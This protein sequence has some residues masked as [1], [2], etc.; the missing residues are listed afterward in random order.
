MVRFLFLFSSTF[1]FFLFQAAGQERDSIYLYNGQILIGTIQAAGLGTITIDDMDFKMTNVK[2]YKIRRL[3]IGNKFKVETIDRKIYEGY[4]RVSDKDGWIY[5]LPDTS[6]FLEI[7]ITDIYLLVS[8]QKNIFKR[9]N[10]D[11]SA[12]L[13]YT[14]S[15]NIGQVNLSATAMWATRHFNYQFV[16]SEIGSIDSSKYSR[17]NELLQILALYDLTPV[18]FLAGMGQYQRNLELSVARRFGELIGGGNKVLVTDEMQLL[19]ITGI[20]LTQ[21]KSTSNVEKGTQFEIPLLFRYNFYRFHHP[22]IQISFSPAVY[23]SLSIPGRLRI[24]GNTSFSWEIIRY[25]YLKLS[26][27]S[28]YDSKPPTTGG[29]T[30]DYGIVF[31]LSYR[32]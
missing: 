24:D 6:R 9:M 18:W 31:S 4:F 19:V 17:D 22:N 21:E 14:K 23:Y 8:L 5:L 3:R 20:S 32:F 30:F 29:S 1:V 28:N 25:F 11:L 13:S 7:R 2:L 26:P 27:Y 10:G 15:S 16:A 12:G